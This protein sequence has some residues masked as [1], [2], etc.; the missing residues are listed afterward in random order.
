MSEEKRDLSL[1]FSLRNVDELED[2][3]RTGSV[4]RLSAPHTL[5]SGRRRKEMWMYTWNSE[6]GYGREGFY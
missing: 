3:F 5:S 4:C 1:S 6:R 2:E